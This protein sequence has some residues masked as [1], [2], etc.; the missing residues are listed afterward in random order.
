MVDHLRL[1]ALNNLA[2]T[3]KLAG[4]NDE[5][6]DATTQGISSQSRLDAF[7]T[8]E[9]KDYRQVSGIID[10]LVSDKLRI[11][12]EPYDFEHHFEWY[13]AVK[14]GFFRS[15]TIVFFVGAETRN[16]VLRFPVEDFIKRLNT[17]RRSY[18]YLIPVLLPGADESFLKTEYW[19]FS[20]RKVLDFSA[21]ITSEH[22]TQLSERIRQS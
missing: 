19:D 20:D 2:N 5:W 12:F 6:L 10:N 3:Y 9:P 4:E 13:G 22:I 16:T 18:G 17:R 1:A 15:R 14:D 8:F 11:W 7:V 21:G